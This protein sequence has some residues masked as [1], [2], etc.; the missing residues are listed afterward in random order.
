MLQKSRERLTIAVSEYQY[1]TQ[2]ENRSVLSDDALS[3]LVS[4][5]EDI[6]G[7]DSGRIRALFESQAPGLEQNP[8]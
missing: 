1:I 8:D 2:I 5:L 3:L 7:W 4:I 6:A